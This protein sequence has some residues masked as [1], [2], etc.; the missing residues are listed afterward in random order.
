MARTLAAAM[1]ALVACAT[2][3]APIGTDAWWHEAQGN[4][5]SLNERASYDLACERPQL[6]MSAAGDKGAPYTSISVSGCGKHNTY[7]W[8]DGAWII[9]NARAYI[10]KDGAW[11][12]DPNPPKS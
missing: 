10:W 3:T 1:L 4:G 9:D 6:V 12:V 8:K 7:I 2:S 11:M 5:V